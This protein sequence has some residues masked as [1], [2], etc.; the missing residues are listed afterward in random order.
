MESGWDDD[1]GE[2]LVGATDPYVR[3]TAKW[4]HDTL[5][6]IWETFSEQV[7]RDPAHQLEFRDPEF[8]D[9]LINE[10]LLGRV[11]ARL[12]PGTLLYRAR[13]G[14]IPGADGVARPYSGP[15]IG[16]P[17][18]DKAHAGRANQEGRVVLYSADQE[19]TAIAEVRPARGEY[20][21]IAELH[22]RKELSIL[23]LG[24]GP[25][26]PN[27]FTA[28][29]LPYEVEFA[30][31]LHAFAEA[32]ARPLRRKDDLADY[33]PSQK[34]A[35]LIERAGLDGIRYPSAMA[36]DG[37]NLLLFAPDSVTIGRSRL[38]EVLETQV[39]YHE[40]PESLV[41]GDVAKHVNL[42]L[43]AAAPNP[44]A[45][46]GPAGLCAPS[47]AGVRPARRATKPARSGSS[48]KIA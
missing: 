38:I 5:A 15:D 47:A 41:I 17:P 16:A 43:G 19:Q 13:L 23:N 10:D 12:P 28:A 34:L 20:V 6:D 7:K 45:P 1:S 2:P 33:L 9:F 24:T 36:P 3:V 39:Q 11:T 25:E 31:L 42:Y 22:V 32:L 26:W 29:S 18:P 27:P 35:E 40:L 37:T 44:G 48:R 4:S 30:E 21:S 46:R 8:H 14:F